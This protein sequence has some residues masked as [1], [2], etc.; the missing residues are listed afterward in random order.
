MRRAGSQS[1]SAAVPAVVHAAVIVK[2]T[3]V[4]EVAAETTI[5]NHARSAS[6]L[7]SY[8][9]AVASQQKCPFN[10]V[11]IGRYTAVIAS[12]AWVPVAVA[13]VATP[14]TSDDNRYGRHAKS[15]VCLQ[16]RLNPD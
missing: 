15:R 4:P 7:M 14:E 8:A 9:A 2:P 12:T 10:R 16:I 3:A 11:A 13:T 1:Q 6:S 5:V